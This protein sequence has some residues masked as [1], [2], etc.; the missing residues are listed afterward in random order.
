VFRILLMIFADQEKKLQY[1]V[2]RILKVTLVGK[3]VV[4][5]GGQDIHGD[6]R[7]S[8]YSW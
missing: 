6:T 2:I 3:D 1:W 5:Q 4:I 7:W 8:R